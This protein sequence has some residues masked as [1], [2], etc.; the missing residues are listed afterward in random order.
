MAHV[1]IASYVCDFGNVIIQ[2][3]AKR[4][5]RLT[6]VGKRKL[7]FTF[8]KKIL[9]AAGI[10][11]EPDKAQNIMPNSSCFFNVLL[12]TR[13]TFKFGRHVYNVPIDVKDGPNYTI[14]FVWNLTIPELSLS[15]ETLDF[16][17]V[18]V[19]TRK[20]VKIRIENNKEVPCEWYFVQKAEPSVTM[21]GFGKDKK[22]KEGERFQVWPHTGTLQPGQRQTVDVMFTP[23]ADKAFGQKLVFMCKQNNKNFILNVKGQGINYQVEC[24]PETIKL[25]PVLPYDTSA[26][27]AFE[28]R[29]P[30]D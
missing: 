26:I 30:M 27:Q 19:N 2:R 20:T 24:I 21:S 4:S 10:T 5:F 6:N 11:I 13:K 3:V 22:E 14:Q 25:G 18:C 17:R 1:N 29:N 12:T 7:S 23:N 9:N 15:Q 8:E 28:I 16:D